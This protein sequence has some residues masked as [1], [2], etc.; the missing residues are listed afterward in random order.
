MAYTWI[1]V[2]LWLVF[3]PGLVK[4]IASKRFSGISSSAESVLSEK[5]VYLPGVADAA[6]GG[7]K[8]S[9]LVGMDT[10]RKIQRE[11]A[12]RRRRTVIWTLTAMSLVSLLAVI[13]FAGR[14]PGYGWSVAA[15]VVSDVLLGAYVVSLARR[16]R[17]IQERRVQV[18]SVRRPPQ[19]AVAPF[20][21][22]QPAIAPFQPRVEPIRLVSSAG[23]RR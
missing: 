14:V 5:V 10:S 20:Q 21:P 4:W 17:R 3:V 12:R 15:H 18:T 7:E 23:G 6:R 11:W 1:V 22:R 8:L 13:I 9:L 16:R 2:A 19:P